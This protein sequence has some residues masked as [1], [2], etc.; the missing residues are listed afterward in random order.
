MK[1]TSAGTDEEGNELAP[2]TATVVF[3]SDGELDRPLPSG[4][5][6]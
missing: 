4:K 2:G 5:F 1:V 6:T 3:D